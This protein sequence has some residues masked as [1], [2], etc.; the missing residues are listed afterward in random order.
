MFLCGLQQESNQ[1]RG[2]GWRED[3]I[4]CLDKKI[5]RRIG[6]LY[7]ELYFGF[8]SVYGSIGSSVYESIIFHQNM[9][10]MLTWCLDMSQRVS[11]CAW[12]NWVARFFPVTLQSHDLVRMIICNGLCHDVTEWGYGSYVIWSKRNLSKNCDFLLPWRDF[13]LVTFGRAAA[14]VHCLVWSNFQS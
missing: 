12:F 9:I 4:Q 8:R 7:F 1:Q 3:F 14:I 10:Q 11:T 6:L 13:E 2:G 5:K